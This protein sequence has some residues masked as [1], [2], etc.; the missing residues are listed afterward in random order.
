MRCVRVKVEIRAKLH[1]RAGAADAGDRVGKR[2]SGM[3]AKR[4]DDERRREAWG[5]VEERQ[6]REVVERRKR[7]S[8]R[9][10]R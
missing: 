7:K 9:D 8:E 3:R 2:A 10:K 5:A 4:C 1:S 6:P